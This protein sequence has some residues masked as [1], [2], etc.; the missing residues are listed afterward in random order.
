MTGEPLANQPVFTRETPPAEPTATP[1]TL[2]PEATAAAPAKYNIGGNEYEEAVLADAVAALNNKQDWQRSNTQTAQQL[3][4][5]RTQL[6]Q[7][8]QEWQQANENWTGFLEAASQNPALRTE[9]EGL[10][11]KATG[12]PLATPTPGQPTAMP[13]DIPPALAAKLQALEQQVAQERQ[14]RVTQEQTANYQEAQQKIDATFAEYEKVYGQPMP[15]GTFDNL[16]GY[17]KQ[18][19]SV[20]PVGAMY[21]V[22]RDQLLQNRAQGATQALNQAQAGIQGATTEGMPAANQSAP[23]D[24]SKVTQEDADRLGRIAATG[25]AETDYNPFRPLGRE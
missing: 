1:S 21:A 22:T 19:G 4:A 20:D 2:T 12:Q 7:Q 25:H 10:M 16:M 5:E 6:Q 14:A 24:L 3:A 18:T 13:S 23:I 15:K 8:V 17:L 9:L 11:A